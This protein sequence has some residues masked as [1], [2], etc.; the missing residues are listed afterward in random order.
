MPG[1]INA[2][3]LYRFTSALLGIC[4]CAALTHSAAAGQ[5]DGAVPQGPR[6]FSPKP[7][8]A[9]LRLAPGSAFFTVDAAAFDAWN[10]EPGILYSLPDVP[11]PEGRSASVRVERFSLLSG[12]ATLL[13]DNAR[14]TEAERHIL[15]TGEIEG[16]TGSRVYLAVFR[17]AVFGYAQHS[18][19]TRAVYAPAAPKSVLCAVTQE[20]RLLKPG[21]PPECHAENL[22]GY[23]EAEDRAATLIGSAPPMRKG[24][25]STQS[26]AIRLNLALDCDYEFYSINSY[27]V[28]ASQ[29]YAISILGAVSD[30]YRRDAGIVWYI[31]YLNVWTTVGP[32]PG[33]GPDSLLTQVRRYWIQNNTMVSRAVAMLLHGPGTGGVA[34]VDVLCGNGYGYNLSGVNGGFT[35]P[36]SGYIW[37]LDV[38]AHELGHNVGS[39]HTHNCGWNPAVDSCVAAEGTC[40]SGTNPVHGTIMSYCHLTNMGTEL[41]FHPRV[42]SYLTQRA[43]AAAC[44]ISQSVPDV[45]AGPPKTMCS[46]AAVTIGNPATNGL[47]PYTYMWWPASG[48]SSTT[49]AQPQASPGVQTKYHVQATD[50]NGFR[51][52]D[53]VVVTPAPSTVSEAGPDKIICQGG[54]TAIGGS[55]TASGGTPPYV[56]AWT[57]G[58]GLTGTN[59]SNPLAAPSSTTR[60]RVQVTDALGCSSQDSVLVTV[61]NALVL[62]AG[63]D[64][65]ICISTSTSIGNPASG[66]QP[67]FAYHWTPATALSD[68]SVATPTATPVSSITYHVTVLDAIGCVAT[69]SIRITV[70]NPSNQNL[71]WTGAVNGD[72]STRGNWDIPC[73]IPGAGSNVTIP[74]GVLSP[75]NVPV[76]AL[77]NLTIENGLPLQLS[78][79]MTINGTLALQSGTILLTNAD[80]VIGPAGNIS[81][82][83]ATNFIVT[84]GSGTLKQSGV[85]AGARTGTV[86]YPVG[87]TA[88]IYAPVEV[89][90]SGTA[91]HFSVRVEPL[92]RQRGALGPPLTSDAVN[93]T[94]H[95]LEGQ[96]GG[97]NVTLALQ[98]NGTDELPSFDRAHSFIS[99][100]NGTLWS[101]VSMPKPAAGADPYTASAASVLYLGVFGVGDLQSPLPVRF[102]AFSATPRPSGVLLQWRT[103]DERGN[104]AFTVERKEAG[105]QWSVIGVVPASGSN[106][107]EY[108]FEDGAPASGTAVYRIRQTDADGTTSVSEELE[109]DATAA[110]PLRATMSIAPHPVVSDAI[111]RITLPAADAISVSVFDALG[112]EALRVLDAAPM[113]A[114][115]H[116]VALRTAAL[117]RGVYHVRMWNARSGITR[118]MV[119][120]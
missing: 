105:A 84:T 61:G 18:D 103:A 30:I 31:S 37:D 27:S 5:G 52:Y 8:P 23:R 98:W 57:P 74:N 88:A 120:E 56:Y 97:S 67:P 68:V 114:G 7:A 65:T 46:G 63:P 28:S 66:G 102:L 87:P 92:A 51:A 6:L 47:P 48:L 11:L 2:Q 90:N 73:A 49:V 26:T 21:A 110:L 69:D 64:Q 15:L 55:P 50:A 22:P 75:V 104:A 106:G 96:L 93:L 44:K 62:D 107:G 101:P 24:G 108:R 86:R 100:H 72:W 4:L 43:N 59:T 35:Y 39:M 42:A 83:S 77:G 79:A 34:W 113:D 81:G 45:N 16:E 78:N 10:P 119:L 32:Y 76:I 111:L 54:G 117:P 3:H 1:R 99:R 112:R 53:S 12:D 58:T 25:A 71:S 85:G 70:D 82:G 80:L 115:Q 41:R 116:A 95:V 40:Y 60:Y 17:G 38:C 94:W 91:D 13:V 19:G 118:R 9:A 33:P 29:A 36:Y 109:I 89:T 20:M 14:R